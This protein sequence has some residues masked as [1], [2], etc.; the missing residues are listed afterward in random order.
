[1]PITTT[2]T[3]ADLREAQERELS[4]LRDAYD[5]LETLAQEEYGDGA[6]SHPVPNDLGDIDDADLLQRAA[7]QQQIALLNQSRETIEKRVNLL[8]VLEAELGDGPFEIKMLSGQEAMN[9]EVDLRTDAN[10]RD[11]DR[12]TLQIVRNQRTVDAAVVDAPDGVPRDDEG[13]PVPSE[14]P[15]ALVNSLF[16]QVQRF[17]SAGQ[18]DFRAEGFGSPAT[19]AP[20]V[21]SATPTPSKQPSAPSAPTDEASPTHGDES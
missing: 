3:W 20:S 16:E 10:A 11:F 9:V 8:G 17:N 19:S 4:D 14:T 13:S 1:M 12:Q 5:E 15:N 21:S 18:T 7:I 6:L 2:V